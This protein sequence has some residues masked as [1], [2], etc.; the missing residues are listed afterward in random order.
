VVVDGV[1]R[2]REGS[3]VQLLAPETQHGAA[4]HGGGH[5]GG[6]GRRA[7]THS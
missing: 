1:D 4:G 6:H 2:L 5:A 7:A 3:V